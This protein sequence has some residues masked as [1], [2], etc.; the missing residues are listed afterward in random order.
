MTVT[1]LSCRTALVLA[2]VVV[3]AIAVHAGE[4]RVMT[5]GAFTAP[6]LELAPQFERTMPAKVVTATTSMG[7]GADSIP[8]RIQRGEAVDVVIL[9]EAAID[10]LIRAGK[11]IADSKVA[12]ARSAIGKRG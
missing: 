2:S 5:S 7:V 9:P 10:D 1:K 4:I 11:V 6:Y 3:A 8:N 12:L